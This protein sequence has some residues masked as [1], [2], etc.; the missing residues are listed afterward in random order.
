MWTYGAQVLTMV[1]QFAYAAV[2][3]RVLGA[4]EFGAYGVALAVSAL[5]VLVANG[6]LGQ[7]AARMPTIGGRQTGALA[8]YAFFL[9]LTGVVILVLTAGLWARLW[10]VPQ[11]EE[12]IRLTAVG[13]FA[14]PW[15]SLGSGLL[16]RQDRF[17]LL[18]A[19]VLIANVS[20]MLFGALAVVI[21]QV[22]WALLVSPLLSQVFAAVAVV[23]AN[24]TVL[25]PR[26]L[27]GGALDIGFSL[28]F[29]VTSIPGYINGNMGKIAVSTVLGAGALGQWNRADVITSV[30][31]LQVQNALIQVA[32]P[33]FRH[34]TKDGNRAR[35]VWVDLLT[36]A[37]W[38]GLPAA[39]A[40]AVV[41]PLAVPVLFGEGWEVAAALAAPLA[42][43][44]GLQ[45]VATVLASAIEAVGR[46]T[47]IWLSQGVLFVV[48]GAAA[49][50]VFATSSWWPVIVGLVVAQIVQHIVQVILCV[51]ARYLDG[52][53]LA[54]R[55]LQAAGGALVCGA[56]ALTVMGVLR[57]IEG[58]TGVMLA[59]GLLG[60]AV[61]TAYR[62][63]AVL[64]PIRV[65]MRY[66]FER[67]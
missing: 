37:A 8:T 56:L 1:V 40:G 50:A 52:K 66:G 41:L 7:T 60:V 64:P 29:I 20:G 14:A 59:T 63:R 33:E 17:R 32:Y 10:S 16:R 25:V 49:T 65:L 9:G 30:P 21:F 35:T 34:D 13:A 42:L 48:Y 43:A 47:W 62:Y 3:A 5:V 12:L 28:R 44:G 4:A 27:R 11:A 31:F 38:I 36:L 24:R 54:V 18:A 46:F 58:V 22:P 15:L 2:T 57:S 26:R 39:A 23:V 67:P 53:L 51:K 61:V 55:Y 45:L 19:I 6:G